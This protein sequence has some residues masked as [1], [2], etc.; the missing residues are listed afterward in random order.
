MSGTQIT[1]E[2]DLSARGKQAGYRRVPH[3]GHRSAYGWSSVPV[4]TIRSGDGLIVVMLSGVY[5]DGYAAQIALSRL[6]RDMSPEPIR[7]HILLLA[8]TNLPATQAGLRVSLLDDG[9]LNRLFPGDA[10]GTPTYMTA[11]CLEN[12]LLPMADYMI[13]LH[14]GGR[15]LFYPATLLGA[16][17]GMAA[18]P[19]VKMPIRAA[20]W[21]PS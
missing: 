12:T 1:S 17:V 8:M 19:R 20:F 7:G 4:A 9:N 3:C 14:P 16:V 10:S 21:R 5:D 18:I 2:I 13:V 11:N 6:A 15:S